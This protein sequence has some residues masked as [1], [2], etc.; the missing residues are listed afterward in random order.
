MALPKNVES[1]H[2]VCIF[3]V[4]W[5]QLSAQGAV[6]NIYL[7]HQLESINH[8]SDLILMDNN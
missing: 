5:R 8:K 7:G 4:A 2:S 1:E 6:L 3:H